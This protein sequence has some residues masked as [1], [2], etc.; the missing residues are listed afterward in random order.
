MKTILLLAFLVLMIAC[1]PENIT[2]T[3]PVSGAQPDLDS[4]TVLKQ[5]T[6]AGQGGHTA[7]GTATVYELNATKYIVLDPYSS[8]G[9]P[10]LKVYLSKDQGATE[11]IRVGQLMSTMGKQTY[12][13][14][15][16]PDL[17]QYPFVHIWCEK[18]SVEFARAPL[19]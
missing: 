9:G 1:Q 10:D 2:P 17:S 13:V 7:S 8:Q 5:G 6:F 18:F 12:Q 4:A 19:Q 14:P 11:F 16:N 3:A 15:G